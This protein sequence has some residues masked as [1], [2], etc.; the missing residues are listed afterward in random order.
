MVATSATSQQVGVWL[1][2]AAVGYFAYR[3]LSSART[4]E[5]RRREQG[6]PHT[7][8]DTAL[9]LLA[10]LSVV[11]VLLCANFLKPLNVLIHSRAGSLRLSS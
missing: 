10:A 7:T 3:L 6:Q 11:G 2:I 1:V 9:L 5:R 8:K 4:E